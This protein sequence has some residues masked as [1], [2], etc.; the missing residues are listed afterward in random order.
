MQ[1][2]LLYKPFEVMSAFTDPDG[3]RTLAEFVEVKGVY[4]A[5]RLDYDSEGLLLLT[6]DT[7]VQHRLTDPTFEH[8]KTYLVQVELHES[9]S[10]ETALQKLREGV[11]LRDSKTK[12]TFRTRP[13]E[14]TLA[15]NP[16]VPPRKVRDYHPT[17]WLQVVLREGKK[18]QL[19]RMT[20][21]VGL[22]CLRLVRVGIG[23]LTLGAL[24]P[25]EWRWVTNEERDEL[26]GMLGLRR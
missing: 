11:T 6:D 22:P 8:P 12:K 14:A 16:Q 4:A 3:R 7:Q 20:A 18:R 25:G 13:A 17:V 21:A 5:G 23:P 26:F 10:I 2:I 9:T 24:Q 15:E 1:Y 19:R